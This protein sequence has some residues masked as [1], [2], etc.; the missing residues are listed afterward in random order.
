M[1]TWAPMPLKKHWKQFSRIRVNLSPDLWQNKRHLW[2]TGYGRDFLKYL[3]DRRL[4]ESKP[5]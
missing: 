5:L 3:T 2:I 4:T 1:V